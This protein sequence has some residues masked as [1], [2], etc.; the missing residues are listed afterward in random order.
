MDKLK[1]VLC[2]MLFFIQ[3]EAKSQN[4]FCE[5]NGNFINNTAYNYVYLVDL[6]TKDVLHSKITNGNFTFKL[7]Q[8]KEFRI[9]HI[10]LE[11][12]SLKEISYFLERSK[13]RS[14]SSRM[15][16]LEN[17]TVTIASDVKYATVKGGPLNKDIDDM[18]SA[19]SSSSYD[20][21]FETHRSTPVSLRLLNT[22]VSVSKIAG[23][24]GRINVKSLFF[25]LTDSLQSSTE[26]LKIAKEIEATKP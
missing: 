3:R 22:L 2:F 15:V 18:N 1:L 16:A 9:M 19:I 12:D 14:S 6:K 24:E 7:T 11:Y 20:E 25:K 13:S 5:I 26:G 4:L 23:L 17:M 10:F 8:P 21:Y